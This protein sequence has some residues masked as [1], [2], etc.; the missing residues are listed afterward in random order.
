MY[1]T[2]FIKTTGLFRVYFPAKGFVAFLGEASKSAKSLTT[3]V[4]Y[5]CYFEIF[6]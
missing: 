3:L 2:L 6:L 5:V 4:L 1:F